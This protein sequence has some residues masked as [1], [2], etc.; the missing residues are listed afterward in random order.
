M[1]CDLNATP[2]CSSDESDSD[3][4]LYLTPAT[5]SS[6]SGEI[7]AV[8]QPMHSPPLSFISLPA[9]TPS[10]LIY[11]STDMQSPI[12]PEISEKRRSI[13]KKLFC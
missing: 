2:L 8:H 7:V 4:D 6:S 3:E 11:G 10:P 9:T 12:T 1:S 5:V 13:V